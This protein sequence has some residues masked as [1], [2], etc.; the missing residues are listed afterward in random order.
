MRK[1]L[2]YYILGIFT[3]AIFSFV[4]PDPPIP[5]MQKKKVETGWIYYSYYYQFGTFVP[6]KL[7][8]CK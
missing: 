1:N 3:V 5:R 7:C 8:S 6:E 4:K 2:M